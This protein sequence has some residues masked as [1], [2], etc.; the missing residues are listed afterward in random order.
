MKDLVTPELR[1]VE[2]L[3]DA[4]YKENRLVGRSFAE[5]SWYF[6]AVCEDWF[7]VPRISD[8]MS[9]TVRSSYEHENLADSINTD[10]K[11]PLYW[12]WK[13]GDKGNSIPTEVDRELYSSAFDLLELSCNY[14]AF[15]SAYTQASIGTSKLALDG[16]VLSSDFTC[17]NDC[18]YDAYDRLVSFLDEGEPILDEARSE[19]LKRTIHSRLRLKGS[20]FAYKLNTRMVN[21]ADKFATIPL[22]RG[23]SLPSEWK[24]SRYSV[25][26]FQRWAQILRAFCFI[27]YIARFE[28]ASQGVSDYGLVDSLLIV[29]KHDLHKRFRKY[30]GLSI[31]VVSALIEDFTYGSRGIRFPDPLLQPLIPLLPNMY[32]IAP[33]FVIN[34]SMERNFSVLMNRIPRERKL[35]SALSSERERLSRTYIIND[36]SKLRM[37]HWWGTVPDWGGGEIDLVLMDRESKSCL[38][39][40]LKSFVAPA[41]IREI[42]DRSEEIADGIEQVRVRKRLAASK[43]APLLRVLDIDPEWEISWAVA[44]ESS[45]GSAFV[46]ADDVPVVRTRH[47]CHKIRRN[48][49]LHGIGEWL[50]TRAYLPVEGKHYSVLEME[51]QISE[52]T[53]KWNGIGILIDDV[54]I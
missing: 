26:E 49:G 37:R 31:P 9:G 51:H 52:W 25:G 4:A 46:Q 15:E 20:R 50:Q 14:T 12:M 6:M 53:L 21:L 41:E 40:E 8:A 22:G 19:A 43:P 13:A 5:A 10:S 30:T 32:A 42:H 7:I 2:R 39:L 48:G 38:I 27:H 34:S 35:Y 54:Y 45:V 16:T 3:I 33:H 44:S 1:R 36:L 29:G 11:W 28:A 24:F 47:L 17:E 23:P 18:T